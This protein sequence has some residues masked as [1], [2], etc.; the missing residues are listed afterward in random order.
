VENLQLVGESRGFPQI[1][2]G[3]A[4]ARDSCMAG[5]RRYKDFDAWKLGEAFRAEVYRL[6]LNSSEAC[7]DREYCCQI[8]DAADGIGSNIAEGFL[9]YSPGSFKQFLDYSVSCLGEAEQRLIKGIA[10]GYFTDA[11][12]AEALRFARRAA[13]AIVRLKQSQRDNRRPSATPKLRRRPTH[14]TK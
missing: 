12:C 5:V 7:E 6:V 10:R 11:A 4:P 13:V 9:R 3:T 14:P 1:V 2:S 8:L